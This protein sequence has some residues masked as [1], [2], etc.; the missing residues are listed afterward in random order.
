MKH[1]SQNQS[2]KP[3]F[4]TPPKPRVMLKRMLLTTLLICCFGCFEDRKKSVP[5]QILP[6]EEKIDVDDLPADQEIPFD[7]EKWRLRDEA[8]FRY[9]RQ[10]LNDIIGSRV[11]KGLTR[12]EVLDLLGEPTRTDKNFLFYRIFENKIGLMTISTK[13]LVLQLNND[14]VVGP[15]LV[16]G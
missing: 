14:G 16:H 9:R 13:T 4:F 6:E 10:M 7:K 2:F 5:H 1:K 8:G 3:L 12:E 11:L 15:V